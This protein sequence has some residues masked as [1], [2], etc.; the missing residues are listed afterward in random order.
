M[1][2]F[3]ERDWLAGTIESQNG[4]RLAEGE[5]GTEVGVEQNMNAQGAGTVGL[6]KPML[7]RDTCTHAI[8]SSLSHALQQVPA[9]VSSM[10][11]LY[12]NVEARRGRR[13]D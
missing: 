13:F 8:M 4:G 2:L 11:C 12:L 6:N 7:T 9:M 1:R 5:R 10:L 3:H